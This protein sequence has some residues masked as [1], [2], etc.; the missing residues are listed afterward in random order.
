MKQ[1]DF[2]VIGH[3]RELGTY[4][5]TDSGSLAPSE[6]D[7]SGPERVMRFSMV[8]FHLRHLTGEI[9]TIAEASIS[10]PARLKAVKSL[11]RDKFSAK[12][13]W[14]YELCG[15]PDDQQAFGVHSVEDI[16]ED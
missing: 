6:L 14:V 15:T 8:A 11:I 9:L 13:N 1:K 5:V 16:R 4:Q 10:D 2:I 12:I 3:N 7:R